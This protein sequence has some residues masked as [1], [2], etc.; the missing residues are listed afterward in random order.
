MSRRSVV[1]SSWLLLLATSG[2]AHGPSSW[3][4]LRS[5]HFLLRTDLD[6]ADARAS[7]LKL[8]LA[9]ATVLPTLQASEL[10]SSPLEAVVF[11]NP[12]DLAT[13]TG[14]DGASVVED[15]RG[16]LLVTTDDAAI[17]ASNPQLERTLHELTHLLSARIFRRLPRWVSEGLAAYLETALI[18]PQTKTARRGRANQVRLGDVE[19]WDLLPV[20]S[21]WAWTQVEADKPG[22]EQHRIASAWFWVYWLLNEHRGQFEGFVRALAR[23]DEP[24]GAWKAAFPSLTTEAMVTES[25]RFR[26]EGKSVGQSLELA[27]IDAQFQVRLLD[28]A[29]VHVLQSRLA[30]ARG[31]WSTASAEADAA[32]ALTPRDGPALEQ[33]AATRSDPAQRLAAAQKLTTEQPGRADGWLLLAMASTDGKDVALQRALELDP[34]APLVTAELASFH[35]ARGETT[36]AID[37][38]RRAF[39]VPANA[40][41]L[42]TSADVL[43]ASGLCGEALTL[44]LRALE[45]LPHRSEKTVGVKLHQRLDELSK[46]AR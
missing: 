15:W 9:R 31:D 24:S 2:C 14:D 3:L 30:A 6:E 46:C 44:D 28:D 4:E 13:A 7:L 26:E 41:V 10:T 35:R 19:R 29:E 45:L 20:E 16:P 43:A 11:A 23:G 1:L 38:A 22:L 8:E 36:A 32:V 18:D 5:P 17:F 40:R 27:G 42:F 33:V 34:T 21:L 39:Q 12:S 25:R 37:L